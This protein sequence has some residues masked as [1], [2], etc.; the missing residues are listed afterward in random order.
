MY[1]L[2]VGC[3]ECTSER[4]CK[5]LDNIHLVLSHRQVCTDSVVSKLCNFLLSYKRINNLLLIA[6]QFARG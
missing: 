3:D 4:I 1:D 6:A 5:I 2:Y